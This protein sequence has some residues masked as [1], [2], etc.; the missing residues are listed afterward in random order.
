MS[1]SMNTIQTGIIT[2]PQATEE[3]GHIFGALMD[4]AKKVVEYYKEIRRLSGRDEKLMAY[5]RSGDPEKNVDKS[6][7]FIVPKSSEEAFKMAEE[8]MK[9]CLKMLDSSP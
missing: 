9:N 2:G 8:T 3:R 5:L 7:G 4:L 1:L 6:D